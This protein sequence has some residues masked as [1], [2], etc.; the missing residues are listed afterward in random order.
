[1]NPGTIHWIVTAQ[2]EMRERERKKGGMREKRDERKEK[3]REER[4]EER[5]KRETVLLT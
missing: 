5:N 3:G 1:M 2:G 4:R